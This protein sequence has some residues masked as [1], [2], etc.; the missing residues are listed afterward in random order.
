V[1]T[2]AGNSSLLA[3]VALVSTIAVVGRAV[4]RLLET[5]TPAPVSGHAGWTAWLGDSFC[6]FASGFAVLSA[7]L[8][9]LA[10]FGHLSRGAV[11]ALVAALLA[12]GLAAGRRRE[13]LRVT[14]RRLV[15]DLLLAAGLLAGAFLWGALLP[16]IDSTLAGSDGSIY[17]AAAHQLARQGGLQHR[18]PLVEE[19]TVEERRAL[20]ANRFP[21]DH[22]GPWARLPGGVPLISPEGSRVTFYFYHLHPVWL[23]V[24]LETV[25]RSY[26]GL[27]P[28]FACLGLLATALVGA[29]LGGPAL[30]AVAGVLLASFYPQVFYSRLP[31]SELLAQALFVSGAFALLRGLGRETDG[32]RVLAGLSWGALSLCRVDGLPLVWLGLTGMA[33]LPARAG[34]RP[35]DWAVPM[36]VTV[37]FGLAALYHQ[38]ANG[39]DYVGP[40]GHA[41]AAAVTALLAGSRWLGTALLA[42]AAAAGALV[43]RCSGAPACAARLR[44]ALKSIGAVGSAVTLAVVLRT[45]EP[46]LVARHLQWIALY[47]T[48]LVLVLL[49]IG[50]ATAVAESVRRGGPPAARASLVLFAGPAVCYLV[51]P[52]VLAFQP[53]VMR[54][55]V[56]IVFPLLFVLCAYGWRAGLVRLC[57]RR[58]TLARALYAGLVIA[59]AAAFVRVSASLVSTG[60]GGF[61]SAS[62]D[63]LARAIPPGALVVVPDADAGTH[64]QTALAFTAGRDVLLLPLAGEPARRLEPVMGS[65]LD[66]QVGRGRRV[67]LLLPAGAQGCG[68]LGARFRP[69]PRLD[70]DLRYQTLPAVADGRLPPPPQLA[71]LRVRLVELRP[72]PASGPRR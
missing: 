68:P 56:P 51:N 15:L 12:L 38:L 27:M 23:A 50:L 4:W 64:L 66:R 21:G 5:D 35:R 10:H 14:A 47:A 44:L 61:A 16:P 70:L 45:F 3:W 25:G 65:F 13:P 62:V 39:I 63:R 37:P 36:L 54:R 17:L 58:A 6:A 69:L 26:L 42:G 41:G 9:V 46:G 71:V 8:F 43:V 1:L 29:R 57:G 22:T 7:G 32:A 24:G 52:M 34:I 33:L 72:L 28:L 60:P 59:T 53:W 49:G 11:A 18:D 55:F 20:F 40:V 30:G 67:F 31:L 48:P 2:A 19:M